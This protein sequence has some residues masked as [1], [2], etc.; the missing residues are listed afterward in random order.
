LNDVIWREGCSSTQEHNFIG[1]A[2]GDDA[3][4]R[5]VFDGRIALEP[6]DCNPFACQ[7]VGGLLV[8]RRD[9]G[10]GSAVKS[11]DVR[12]DEERAKVCAADR[13]TVRQAVGPH[14]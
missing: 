7:L 13:P 4:I 9:L 10:R 11:R 5:L 3:E 12:L 1:I 8:P 14:V 2:R 6:A